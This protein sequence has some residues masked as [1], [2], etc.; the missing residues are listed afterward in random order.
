MDFIF[1]A[2]GLFTVFAM[3]GLV[4]HTPIPARSEEDTIRTIF[5]SSAAMGF[6]ASL[7]YSSTQTVFSLV[8]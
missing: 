6:G 7:F 2:I 8:G 4:F 3:L 5:L 1:S